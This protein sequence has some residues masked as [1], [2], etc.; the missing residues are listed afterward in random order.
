MVQRAE[1][2]WLAQTAAVPS[3]VTYT[4]TVDA[5]IDVTASILVTTSSAESFPLF[6][7]YTDAGGTARA[8]IQPLRLING[9]NVII[10]NFANG[11]VPYSGVLNRIRV[12]G[13]TAVTLYT[14][15]GVFTG[16]TYNV[17]GSI[18][19]SAH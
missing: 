6:V 7:S 19:E 1:A 16:C 14:V 2:E 5:T 18:Y 12:K 8:A 3:I 13:G 15:G 9:N 11:A 17:G 10:V 4:P